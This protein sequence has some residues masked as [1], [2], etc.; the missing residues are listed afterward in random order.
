MFQ[1]TTLW[2]ERH[3]AAKRLSR[4]TNQRD[5]ARDVLIRVPSHLRNMHFSV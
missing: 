5:V 3:L 1:D 4:R 2:E